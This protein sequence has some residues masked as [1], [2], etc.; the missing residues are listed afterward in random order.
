VAWFSHFLTALVENERITKTE[1]DP[2]RKA[3]ALSWLF[4]LVGDI[5][6]PLHSIQ[7]FTTDY[8][9]GDRGGNEICV[10]PTQTSDAMPLHIFWDRVITSSSNI[11]RLKNE[12]VMLRNRPVFSKSE[13]TELGHT[14]Y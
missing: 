1:T 11:N 12:A 9:N 14:D 3:I 10:R 8:P 13:L 2:Q 6:Q 4:H 5:H 7:I